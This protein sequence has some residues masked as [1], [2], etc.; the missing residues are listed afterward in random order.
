[1]VPVS[2]LTCGLLSA[3]TVFV[4][5]SHFCLQQGLTIDD[6]SIRLS[7]PELSF[8][9]FPKA[10]AILPFPNLFLFIFFIAMVFLGIDS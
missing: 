6:P 2:I 7:G 5:L 1:M 10:L 8:N 9:V 4:Y 3:M